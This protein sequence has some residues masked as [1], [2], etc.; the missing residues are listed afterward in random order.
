MH[1]PP[2]LSVSLADP[3]S[4]AS[5]FYNTD[6]RNTFA[7]I[8][9]LSFSIL[10]SDLVWVLTTI[11]LKT[12]AYSLLVTKELFFSEVVVFVYFHVFNVHNEPVVSTNIERSLF[13]NTRLSETHMIN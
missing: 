6:F 1:C 12:E 5:K 3:I 9:A 4:L 7:H 11:I 8:L 13:T 10:N 2:C